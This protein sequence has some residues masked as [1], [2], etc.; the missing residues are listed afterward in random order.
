MSESPNHFL[1]LENHFDLLAGNG[2]RGALRRLAE[3]ALGLPAVRACADRAARRVARGEN[4]FSAL[5]AEMNI[6]WEIEGLEDHLPREGPVVLGANHPFGGPE[7]LA[8]PSA[9]IRVRSDVKVLGNSEVMAL[10]GLADWMFPLDIFGEEGSERRN[11]RVLKQSLGHLRAGGALIV[12]PAGAVSYW[13]TETARV[14]DPPWPVHT[15]RMIQK[16]KAPYLPVRF[17]GMNGPIFQMLGMIHPTIRSAMIPRAFL[18]MARKTV[19]GK[20]GKLCASSDFPSDPIEMTKGLREA[21][22]NL[23]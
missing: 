4:G 7:A 10:P 18:A 1:P 13:Q 8:L 3:G 16:T 11:I 12:F 6:G 14:E 5:L 15:A 17:F 9:A 23:F 22:E 21:V 2:W 20:A 19:S